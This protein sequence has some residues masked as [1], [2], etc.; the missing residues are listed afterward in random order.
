[1]IILVIYE[2]DGAKILEARFDSPPMTK[3][4]KDEPINKLISRKLKR[5]LEEWRSWRGTL[6]M[7]MHC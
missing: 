7:K 4:L 5:S 6:K 1:M 2:L 3:N